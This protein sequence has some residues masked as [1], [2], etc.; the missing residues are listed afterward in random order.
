[1]KE[2][3]LDNEL[4]LFYEYITSFEYIIRNFSNYIKRKKRNYKTIRRNDIINDVVNK[5]LNKIIPIKLLLHMKCS[6]NRRFYENL[7][8]CC[9][10]H[11]IIKYIIHDPLFI[12]RG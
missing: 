12:W 7:F 8:I 11:V 9:Y 5:Y 2:L 10:Y 6:K 4:E 3:S 1:M